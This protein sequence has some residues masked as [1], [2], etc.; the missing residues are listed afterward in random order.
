[1]VLNPDGSPNPLPIIDVYGT[2]RGPKTKKD[3]SHESQIISS[4]TKQDKSLMSLLPSVQPSQAYL[5]EIAEDP[6][7]CAQCDFST[8]SQEYFA[9]HLLTAHTTMTS[10]PRSPAILIPTPEKVMQQTHPILIPQNNP[11]K[12]YLSWMYAQQQHA[13]DLYQQYKGSA[14]PEP[15]VSLAPDPLDLS[16]EVKKV[17]TEILVSNNNNNN[18]DTLPT[19]PPTNKNRRKGKAFKLERISLQQ[20]DIDDDLQPPPSKLRNTESVREIS[21]VTPPPPTQYLS[22][23]PTH[24]LLSPQSLSNGVVKNLSDPSNEERKSPVTINNG[25]PPSLVLTH[26][27][28]TQP[29][30]N[31]SYCDILFKD[32][33]MYTMHMGYHGYKDPFHCNMCGQQTSDKLSFFL[34]I[35]RSSHS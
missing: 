34:H 15:V 6:H 18:I 16:K 30:Y 28:D 33:V 17:E 19:P 7:K 32:V 22:P 11:M 21:S 25:A 8:S 20:E 27:H 5:N 26:N 2:R 1:M 14:L 24:S 31:C 35:A 4:A 10:K 13:M 23:K 12:D 29:T 9:Q 3:H